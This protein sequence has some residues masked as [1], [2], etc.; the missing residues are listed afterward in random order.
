MYQTTADIITYLNGLNQGAWIALDGVQALTTVTYTTPSDISFNIGSGVV[1][2][3]FV[4]QRTGEIKL[5][6]AKMFGFP[7]R[8]T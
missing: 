3:T 5:F 7:E 1:I 2:K 8:Q 6:P 4:N